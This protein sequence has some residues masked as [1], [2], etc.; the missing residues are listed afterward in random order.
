MFI[1]H[2]WGTWKPLAAFLV[3]LALLNLLVAK[4]FVSD[5]TTLKAASQG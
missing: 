4:S 3:V 2:R 5:A 1:H